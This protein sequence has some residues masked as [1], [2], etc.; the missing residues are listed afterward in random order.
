[1]SPAEKIASTLGSRV[2]DAG[3]VVLCLAHDDGT[4]SLSVRD[5]QNGKVLMRC[6]AGCEQGEVIAALSSRKLWLETSDAVA[7]FP[8]RTKEVWAFGNLRG[9]RV[10]RSCQET[11]NTTSSPSRTRGP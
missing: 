9:R 6:H 10:E 3:W 4:P 1:V 8:S 5:A 11:K 2:A 7:A